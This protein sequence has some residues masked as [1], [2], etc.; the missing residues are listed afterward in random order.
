MADNTQLNTGVGGDIIASDD[1]G[2][3]KFQRVKLVHGADGINAG[4]V[5]VLN[6]LP[7]YPV[8][9]A[10]PYWPSYGASSSTA[11]RSTGVDEG[12]ALSVRG[13]VLT[14][15]GTFRCNFA[16]TS[17][18]V[19]I[20]SVMVSGTTVTGTGFL[21]G[22]AK[23][24]D[25]FKLDADAESAWTQ[26]SSVDSDTQITLYTSYSG[27]ASGSASRAI[28]RP[29][30]GSGGSIS[31]ASGQCTLTSGTT[32]SAATSI[33]RDLD[34]APIVTRNRVSI[35]QRI[36]NQT[37][38]IGLWEGVATPRFFARFEA[39]GTTNTTIKCRSGRNPTGAPS[40][41]ETEE[42]VVTL[43]N[44][45]TTATLAE[46]RVEMLTEVVRFY[47]AGIL[48]AE[49]ARV[50]P[51]QFD[52]FRCGVLIVNGTGAG[53]STSV[54]AD[55]ITGKNHNKL[56]VG[57]MSDAEKIVASQPPVKTFNYSQAGVIAINTDLLTI[58]CTHLRGI[59]LQI[60]SLGTSGQI[61]PQWS[62]D[63]TTWVTAA[64]MS[65]A[66]GTNT[67]LLTLAGMF[68]AHV[69]ARFLRFRLTSA[70]TGGTTTL[71]VMGYEWPV[72]P[73]NGVTVTG[74]VTI[75]TNAALVAGTAAVGDVGLQ[76]RA[77]ATGAMT[78]AKILAA[79]TTNATSVKASAGRVFGWQLTN[80][81][82]AAKYV[83]LYNL[84]TAPTVGTST[85]VYNIVLPANATVNATFPMGIGHS[86]GI[87]YAI[88][89]AIAD[90]DATAVAANDVLGA[91]YYA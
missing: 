88:T 78:V 46:Y 26:I 76:V 58:D 55:Y 87:A 47:I 72:G 71:S 1:I 11:Q 15:E 38:W 5:S 68:T 2:G 56:E 23:L 49:H 75:G 70:T 35:S 66:G 28:M 50:V 17:L 39:D 90:L 34:Y 62:N 31:V 3:V 9:D 73:V 7:S 8:A 77:N 86:T 24:K 43:P 54:I 16:N 89:N 41:S 10:V 30:T 4:D 85:P 63:G 45:L 13:A 19:S 83:R 40:A 53:S 25:Y 36:A 18:A 22:E 61:T 81:T 69:A 29:T 65:A 12:G 64:F 51:S 44:G 14:D 27:G 79:A 37:I 74:S 52:F 6:G 57:V 32:N 80:T 21:T 82:A 33:T 91:I 42:T 60:T 59:S 20:G 67:Q 84:A 48:V